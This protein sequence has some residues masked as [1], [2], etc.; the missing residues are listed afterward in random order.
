MPANQILV[1]QLEAS[2]V[3]T[4]IANVEAYKIGM[5]SQISDDIK[6]LTRAIEFIAKKLK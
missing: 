4:S 6:A 3:P 1:K 5:L 2:G